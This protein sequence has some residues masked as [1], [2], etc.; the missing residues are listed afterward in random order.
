MLQS[1]VSIPPEILEAGRG[2]LSVTHGVLDVF[3]A[4]VGLQRPRVVPLVG[5]RVLLCGTWEMGRSAPLRAADGPHRKAVGRCVSP[6]KGPQ[7]SLGRANEQRS[8]QG[9]RLVVLLC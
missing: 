3:V 4:E 2:Q 5:Q 7:S 9:G 1:P 6:P 8:P